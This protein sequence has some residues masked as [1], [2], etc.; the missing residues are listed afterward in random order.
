MEHILW[1]WHSYPLHTY[2]YDDSA[3]LRYYNFRGKTC[4]VPLSLKQLGISLLLCTVYVT[5]LCADCNLYINSIGGYIFQVCTQNPHNHMLHKMFSKVK[6]VYVNNAQC[7]YVLRY[8]NVKKCFT[9]HTLLD[10]DFVRSG[11]QGGTIIILIIFANLVKL[12]NINQKY[13][14]YLVHLRI[15]F[16]ILVVFQMSGYK[17]EFCGILHTDICPR[18]SKLN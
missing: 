7:M 13:R 14:N 18:I 6:L 17:Y 12:K 3:R 8:M 11:S 5:Y 16:S 1:R 15:T 2:F 10:V 9:Y 4:L